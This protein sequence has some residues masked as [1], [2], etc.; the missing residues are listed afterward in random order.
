MN[1]PELDTDST[2]RPTVLVVA[3]APV[4]GLAKTRVATTVGHELAAELA[5]A[6]L[7][8]TLEAVSSTGWPIVIAMTG[9][10]GAAAR[11]D[12][13]C[14]AIAPFTVIE[15]RG[16]GL[17]ERLATAHADADAGSGIVQIGMDTP[18]L[19]AADLWAAGEA[20]NNHDA[21]VGPAIDGGWWLLALR[22]AV[23]AN[24]LSTVPMSRPD[25]CRLTLRALTEAG[26]DVGTIRPLSDVDHWADA[27]V[28]AA[29][30]PNLRMSA[31]VRRVADLRA[32]SR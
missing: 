9:D 5:A 25:T 2:K 32:V 8:D 28:L 22:S 24:I 23:H 16:K 29:D 26:A 1:G 13:I 17:G 19:S 10:L 30:Y 4:P 3:K 18:Q 12:E 20:L 21:V 15:Q 6:A 27:L 31:V 14:A 7:L 11:G